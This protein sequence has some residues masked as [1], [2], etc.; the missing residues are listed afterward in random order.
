[1]MGGVLRCRVVEVGALCRRSFLW[2][3]G[4]LW[5]RRGAGPVDGAAGAE[6][7][8]DGRLGVVAA[9]PARGSRALCRRGP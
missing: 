4:A 3:V 8:S 7:C 2:P 9:R 1:M 6:K 5:C